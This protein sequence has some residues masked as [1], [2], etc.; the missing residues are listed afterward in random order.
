VRQA[1]ELKIRAL[2]AAQE[3]PPAHIQAAERERIFS[4]WAQAVL[5]RNRVVDAIEKVAGHAARA[6]LVC[7]LRRAVL[8]GI[9]L[10][11]LQMSG[12]DFSGA[13]LTDAASRTLSWTARIS[14]RSR[15]PAR[16]FAARA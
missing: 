12:W 2:G 13:D 3:T 10:D 8:P 16:T 5:A 1:S 9:V 15:L 14:A 7:S 4:A 11:G 6:E